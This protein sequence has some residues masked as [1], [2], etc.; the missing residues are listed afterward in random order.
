MANNNITEIGIKQL[1]NIIKK[2]DS[3]R[4]PFI[5]NGIGY[6]RT[7]TNIEHGIKPEK[8]KPY[9]TPESRLILINNGK[10]N[11]KIN[12]KPLIFVPKSLITVPAK[13]VFQID[14]FSDDMDITILTFTNNIIEYID[15]SATKRILISGKQSHIM[16]ISESD[17]SLLKDMFEMISRLAMQ[18]PEKTE[19]IKSMLSSILH[20][21]D[22]LKDITPKNIPTTRS[23]AI[24]NKFIDDLNRYGKTEHSVSFYANSQYISQRH[25]SKVIKEISGQNPIDWINQFI[26]TEAKIMLKY[27]DMKIFEIA[28]WLNISN[29]SFFCKFFKRHTGKSPA[30]YRKEQAV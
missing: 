19:S 23:E 24:Y 22:K 25:F 7:S 29:E 28:D 21:I 2:Y 20:Y 3:N 10:I 1:E 9:F 6:V 5:N 18:K 16:Q 27:T 14:D 12:L 4:I 30:A 13:S 17:F 11:I 26:M 8:G 15:E